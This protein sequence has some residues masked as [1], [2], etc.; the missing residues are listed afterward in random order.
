MRRKSLSHEQ[1]GAIGQ[2]TAYESVPEN[3][4]SWL[5]DVRTVTICPRPFT[6]FPFTLNFRNNTLLTEEPIWKTWFPAKVGSRFIPR[7]S[8]RQILGLGYFLNPARL[9][10]IIVRL[11]FS[12]SANYGVSNHQVE[13]AHIQKKPLDVLHWTTTFSLIRPSQPQ[14]STFSAKFRS[15]TPIIVHFPHPQHANRLLQR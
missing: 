4:S 7:T 5:D 8:S 2:L 6:K 14:K 10:A 12:F 13:V 1:I 9:K 11:V 3:Q 15:W